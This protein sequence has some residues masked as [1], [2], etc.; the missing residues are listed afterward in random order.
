MHA[1]ARLASLLA[2][3]VLLIAGCGSESSSGGDDPA[4]LMPG[5]GIFYMEASV[6][7]EGDKKEDALAAAG[8]VLR[9]DDPAKRITE[10][11][12]QAFAESGDDVKFDYARDI[13]PWLGEKAAFWVAL[14]ARGG[15]EPAVAVA[16]AA[17]DTEKAQESLD[18]A[19]E[20]DADKEVSRS[21]EGVDYKVGGEDK[22]A[23]GIVGD[24]VVFGPEPSFKKV[25]DVAE[26]D[27]DSMADSKAYKDSLNGLPEE[28]LAHFFVDLKSGYEFAKQQDPASAQELQQFEQL[29]D[30]SKL[31][32]ITGSFTADGSKL[33]LDTVANGDLA[34]M[35]QQFGFVTGSASTPLV[36]E[37]PGES[38]AAYGVPKLG[39]SAKGLYQKFAGALGGAAIQEQ[40]RQQYGIDLE[41]D[42][43]S[44]I[45]DAAIFVRGSSPA[46]IDGALVIESTDDAAAERAI[47]KF[48]GILRQQAGVEPQPT[49]IEGAEQAFAIAAPGAPQQAVVARGEGRV[50]VS[51]GEA[52]ARDAFSPSSKLA[53]SEMYKQGKAALGEFEPTFL[54]SMPAVLGLVDAS[55]DGGDPSY[56]QAR[57]YLDVFST[58]ASG[59]KVDGDRAESRLAVGLK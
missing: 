32:P 18:R 34:R 48:L 10:L 57:P 50:V 29:F 53:D 7:P 56:Q 4:A 55:P 58:I 14:P 49:S 27:G 26:K 8:K 40:L 25:V 5:G 47:G 3:L 59:G 46:E 28:R 52:A 19:L 45:G 44:W 51:F 39:E 9:T 20:Q 54:L 37:L 13:E 6:R 31:G 22:T 1:A 12:N 16:I 15:E 36:G 21:Y 30:V 35:I 43:F 41:Q 42:V 17:T 11:V 23:I 24:F 33:A 2:L 38:W